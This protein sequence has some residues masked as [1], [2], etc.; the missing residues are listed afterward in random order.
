MISAP[1]STQRRSSH[2]NIN[3]KSAGS[4][5]RHSK[6]GKG[7]SNY[8]NNSQPSASQVRTFNLIVS[9]NGEASLTPIRKHYAQ[10][11]DSINMKA[12]TATN[13]NNSSVLQNKQ[14]K[15]GSTAV[16]PNQQ[17]RMQSTAPR[18]FSYKPKINDM[19]GSPFLQ[20][21]IS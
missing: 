18:L 9:Q 19:K 15:G 12:A 2:K 7:R 14:Q 16:D 10:A 11:H 13:V 8:H 1:A 5:N 20:P 6:D 4:Q 21:I 17:R 3:K